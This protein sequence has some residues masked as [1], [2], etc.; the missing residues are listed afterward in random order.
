LNKPARLSPEELQLV[1][2]HPT[3]AAEIIQHIKGLEEVAKIVRHHHERWDGKGYP[4][5]LSGEEIP[6]GARILCIA[7]AFEAMTSNRPYRKAM[8]ISEAVSE[9]INNAG[10]Q[11]D[12]N[13]VQIF[14]EILKEEGV[15]VVEG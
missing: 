10:E 12:P 15:S 3:I 5:G 11:F 13:L 4:D 14:L 1:K 9:L 2:Q 6:L 7:D 8:S